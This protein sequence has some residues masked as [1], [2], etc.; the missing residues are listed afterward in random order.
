MWVWLA[1][2]KEERGCGRREKKRRTGTEDRTSYVF[3]RRE[4]EVIRLEELNLVCL[5]V[6]FLGSSFLKKDL[7][8]WKPHHDIRHEQRNLKPCKV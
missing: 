8:P 7:Y 1:G 6:C 3:K 2:C 5:F 4:R